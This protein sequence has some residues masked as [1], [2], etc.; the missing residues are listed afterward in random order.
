MNEVMDKVEDQIADSGAAVRQ[1]L[2]NVPE[3]GHSEVLP[4]RWL[5]TFR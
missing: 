1:W 4:D 2:L 5:L 3:R